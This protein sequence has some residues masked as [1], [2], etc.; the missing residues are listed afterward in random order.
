MGC[1]D[2]EAGAGDTGGRGKL[3]VIEDTNIGLVTPGIGE[4]Q[5]DASVEDPSIVGRT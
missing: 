3:V 5:G 4:A 2:S 1:V